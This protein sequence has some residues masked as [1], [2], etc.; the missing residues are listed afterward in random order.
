MANK[1]VFDQLLVLR[2]GV[3]RYYLFFELTTSF[4]GKL[5]EFFMFICSRTRAKLA[6][7]PAT[8]VW[9]VFL[10]SAADRLAPVRKQCI[11]MPMWCPRGVSRCQGPCH[12]FSFRLDASYLA[13][14]EV[15]Q[16]PAEHHRG[17]DMCKHNAGTSV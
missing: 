17:K 13:F 6:T 7:L 16:G 14:R 9:C 5:L 1:L 4:S 10:N 2:V 12:L 3:R 8:S 15:A 11:T